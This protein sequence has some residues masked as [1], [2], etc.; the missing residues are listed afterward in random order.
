MSVFLRCWHVYDIPELLIPPLTHS[1][2]NEILQFGD[3]CHW[4][5]HTFD[6][7]GLLILPLTGFQTMK[8][9]VSED[10]IMDSMEKNRTI[11]IHSH[12]MPPFDSSLFTCT[13]GRTTTSP[14][15]E[16]FIHVLFTSGSCKPLPYTNYT[17]RY[18]LLNAYYHHYGRRTA[19]L[20]AHQV[21]KSATISILR[22]GS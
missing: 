6:I 19:A 20:Q 10:R 17:H 15:F 5:R 13:F 16:S 1:R 22:A 11:C 3:C 8:I 9:L 2:S 18:K 14:W 7:P 21:S 4:Q 12:H